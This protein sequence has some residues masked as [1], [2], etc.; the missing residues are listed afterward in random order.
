[1]LTLDNL[2]WLITIFSLIGGQLVIY[3]KK[4]GYAIWILM[5]FLWMSYFIYKGIYSSAT[6]F[7]VYFIQSTYGYI[8]WNQ[9]NKPT[10]KNPLQ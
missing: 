6:L 7:L 10:N 1:M 4:S 9:K 8:K 3:K 2:T 5:N